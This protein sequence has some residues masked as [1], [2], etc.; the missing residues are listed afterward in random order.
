MGGRHCGR[1]S[2]S[3]GRGKNYLVEGGG[4]GG[5]RTEQVDF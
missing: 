5:V 4:R 2:S 3:M 1:K